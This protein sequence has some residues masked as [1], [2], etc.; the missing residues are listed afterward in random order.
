MTLIRNPKI[1]TNIR[2]L[3]ANANLNEW[4]KGFLESVEKY[5]SSHG[6]ISNKQ[7]IYLT[8]ITNKYK[9]V[10]P[11]HEWK[12][13]FQNYA[14]LWDILVKFYAEETEFYKSITRKWLKNPEYIP[15]EEEFRKLHDN[16]YAPGIISNALAP[17][18]YDVGEVVII[19]KPAL[20]EKFANEWVRYITKL[21]G[22]GSPRSNYEQ[23]FLYPFFIAAHVNKFTATA[24]SKRYKIIPILFP[25]V[26]E[27]E[28]RWIKSAKV[29]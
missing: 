14:P 17:H 20:N 27:V 2:D 23:K 1:P 10:A 25:V 15:T 18:K 8:K 26:Y 29:K 21:G 28:E 4:E 16:K 9:T 24:G 19:R 11:S 6:G 7:D 5:F 22:K 12:Q 13:K 3:L